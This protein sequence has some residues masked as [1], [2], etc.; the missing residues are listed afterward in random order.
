MLCVKMWGQLTFNWVQSYP[1]FHL[2]CHLPH[3]HFLVLHSF[4]LK[5]ILANLLTAT[6]GASFSDSLLAD[7]FGYSHPQGLPQPYDLVLMF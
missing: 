5:E 6:A 1:S 7:C 4:L 3:L 2:L